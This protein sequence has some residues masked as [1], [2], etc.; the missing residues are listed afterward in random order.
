M[1][2]LSTGNTEPELR[3][4]VLSS[5]EGN[6]HWCTLILPTLSFSLIPVLSESLGASLEGS[7][8]PEGQEMP[9]L[10]SSRAWRRL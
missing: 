2:G 10:R 7:R 1:E 3:P 9:A 5:L 6:A 8:T 4:T